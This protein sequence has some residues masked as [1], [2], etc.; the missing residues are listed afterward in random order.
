M[1]CG[2]LFK[3]AT[4]HSSEHLLKTRPRQ[5]CVQT[6]IFRRGPGGG[7]SSSSEMQ[8]CEVRKKIEGGY[9]LST[10]SKRNIAE[11]RVRGYATSAMPKLVAAAKAGPT[12]AAST[13]S[14]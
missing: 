5:L 2:E 8:Q 3:N 4:W 1:Q 11:N 10:D 12:P 7:P 6:R 9:D 14:G 13:T